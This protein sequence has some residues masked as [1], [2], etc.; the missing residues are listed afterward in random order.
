MK[1]LNKPANL[2]LTLG[3]LFSVIIL[4]YAIY[5][6]YSPIIV[7]SKK[8][9]YISILFGLVMTTLFSLGL[10]L[11]D[12]L[13]IN[14]SLLLVTAIILIYIFETFLEFSSGQYDKRTPLE[15]ISDLNNSGKET[16]PNI[17]PS[18]F[19]DS[20]G[21]SVFNG[22]LYP[23]GGISNITTILTNESGYY[24]IIQTDEHGFNNPKGLYKI[25]PLDIVLVGD[26]YAEGYSVHSDENI[27]AVLRGLGFNVISFGKGGNG[28]LIE[29]ASLKE[30]AEPLKPKI[31]LW[32]YF[33]NDL[34]GHTVNELKSPILKKY[35]D[36][37]DFTQNLMS[38]QIEIDSILKNYVRV[39]MESELVKLSQ[40]TVNWFTR[41]IKL[42][43]IRL[44][45]KLIAVLP[46]APINEILDDEELIIVK[47]I[48]A[49]SKKMVSDWGGSL[50]FVYLP[51]YYQYSNKRT[52][53][54]YQ[55]PYEEFIINA[56][57]ELDIPIIN[58]HKEV[59]AIHPDPR[60]LFPFRLNNHLNP[61]GIIHYNAKGYNLVAKAISKKILED[62]YTVNNKLINN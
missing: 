8:L 17:L 46:P 31:V 43:N 42:F 29:F 59:F 9:Y 39:E 2:V 51:D 34:G 7:V 1:I 20:N 22:R 12:E 49:K 44:R 28:P 18:L 23:L 38:R 33:L 50:Y 52:E 54:N 55:K 15:V 4:L 6:L 5:K 35:I 48:L 13:K 41:I 19:K 56:V 10:R 21:L 3:I 40:T 24:P 57:D 30:Y 36:D 47:N 16:Y 53:D 62:G 61:S 26:S 14:L 11:R 37:E 32:L 60:S 45:L 27:G 25:Q 58:I